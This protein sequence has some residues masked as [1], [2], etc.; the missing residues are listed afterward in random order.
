MTAG[1]SIRDARDAIRDTLAP[2]RRSIRIVSKQNGSAPHPLPLPARLPALIAERAA[3]AAAAAEHVPPTLPPAAAPTTVSRAAAA[4]RTVVVAARIAPLVASF[5]RDH[6]RWLVGGGPVPRSATFH[7]RRAERLVRTFGALGPTFV[8]LAQLLGARADLVPEPYLGALGTLSDQVPPVSP[9]AVAR[10]IEESYGAPP[11]RVFE[12]FDT[13]PLA[14]ASLGQV[15]RAR[16]HGE[17]VVVKVLRPG[18]ERLVAADVRAADRLLALAERYLPGPHLRGL[19]N[20][21]REFGVRVWEEMDFRHEAANA[22]AVRANFLARGGVIV[23]RVEPSLVRRRA[24]VM[25]YAPG[26]RIDRLQPQ[27]AAGRI[28]AQ[29]LVRRVIE[30]YMRMM[31]V[32]GF[33]HADPHPGNLLVQDD[34]TIVIVDFGMV[35]PVAKTLRRQLARTAFA[36]IRRD[37]DGLVD[38][39]YALG[40]VGPEADRTV[41]RELVDALLEVAYAP[42]T[43]SVDRIAL[44]ADRVMHTLYRFPVTLPS[45]L[46]YFARTAALIEGLGARYDARFNGVTFASPVALR[47]QREI[48]ASLREPGETD[49][50]F[51]GADLDVLGAALG[52]ALGG[53]LGGALGEIVGAVASA[54]RQVMD[55]LD[56]LFPPSHNGKH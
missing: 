29:E 41:L 24:L 36:G 9:D 6:R 49:L 13:V 2:P 18:V 50:A 40:V 32:D 21:T 22:Q 31:L 53:V 28:D 54:G 55:F 52:T 30:L 35:V 27:V 3:S 47:L 37:A 46:V 45:D 44:L 1:W 7:A 34:G 23:P 5:V 14:A 17:E 51:L 43:T 56:R 4:W 8:K 38:G 15:H 16:W 25:E 26:T 33:F 10:V 19:R 48:A 12:W 20:A 39:F 42:D 11:E